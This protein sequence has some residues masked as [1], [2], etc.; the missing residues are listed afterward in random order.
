MEGLK[1]TLKD[2]G[3]KRREVVANLARS[4]GGNL[5]AFYYA[6]GEDDIYAIVVERTVCRVSSR[7]QATTRPA[8]SLNVNYALSTLTSTR[9]RGTTKD[10]RNRRKLPCDT[11]VF[12]SKTSV[13]ETGCASARS[14]PLV[15]RLA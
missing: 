9:Y 5:E 15:A 12:V 6:F 7:S 2:G 4:L 1:G 10:S 13:S 14:L 11:K 3:T 8:A